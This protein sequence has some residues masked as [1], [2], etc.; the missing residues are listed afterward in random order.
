M[1]WLRAGS[2]LILVGALTL[3]HLTVLLV[4]LLLTLPS[5]RLRVRWQ[6]A[7]FRAWS[8]SLLPALGVDVTTIG[9]PPGQPFLLVCNHL[10]YLDIPL[11][12]SRVGGVFIAKSEIA[13]WPV[14]GLLC[15]AVNTIFIDRSLRRDIPRVMRAIDRELALGRGVVLFAEGTSSR[16]ATVLPFRTSLLE[17]AVRSQ[18]P[19]SC[20]ALS[21]NTSENDEPADQSVCWWGDM[22]FTGHALHF[23]TLRRVAAR[24]A[25]G[26]DHVPGTD[27]KH[28]AD[29]LRRKVLELFEPVV[30]ETE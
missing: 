27:R 16:G 20:A 21:Y 7:V 29:V 5:G 6:S 30:E 10:S 8:R 19:V 4:G 28:L 11:L 18:H 22:E 13:G 17:L 24:L 25:F 3:F 2:R 12:G 23:L 14:I 26:D 1:K 9:R 15:R